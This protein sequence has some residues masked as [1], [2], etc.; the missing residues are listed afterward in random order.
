MWISFSFAK[1]ETIYQISKCFSI[2]IDNESKDL[3]EFRYQ[4]CWLKTRFIILSHFESRVFFS[5][6][7]SICMWRYVLI[8][9][10]KEVFINISRD[11]IW[12]LF[13]V[14][15]WCFAITASV[16]DEK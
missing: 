5:N 12:L 9:K 14:Y 2:W 8:S 16:L 7:N 11:F 10:S 13:W 4:S 1:V 6:V 15:G 3:H